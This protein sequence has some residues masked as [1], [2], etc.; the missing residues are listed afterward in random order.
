MNERFE[1]RSQRLLEAKRRLVILHADDSKLDAELFS[2]AVKLGAVRAKVEV[3]LHQVGDGEKAIKYLKGIEEFRDGGEDGMPHLIVTDVKMPLVT[4]IELLE[5]MKKRPE[6]RGIGKVVLSG[7]DLGNDIE[8]SYRAGANTYFQKPS[9]M[10]VYQEII[11]HLIGYWGH[12]PR[13]GKVR[14]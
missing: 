14:R 8:K 9:T 11:Y 6:F 3:E 13:D 4:G 2:H 1:I 7:S 12:T 10:E 5:W